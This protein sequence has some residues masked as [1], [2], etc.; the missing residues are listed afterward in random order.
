MC[1]VLFSEQITITSLNII[2]LLFFIT[3][4]DCVY[5]AVGTESLNVI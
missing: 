5:C 1:Y 2:K 3:E 4:M